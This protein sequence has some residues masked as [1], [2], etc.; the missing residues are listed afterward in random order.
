M[1]LP[2]PSGA[3]H[4]ASAQAPALPG[5]LPRERGETVRKRRS[6]STWEVA[7]ILLASFVL[8]LGVRIYGEAERVAEIRELA[9]VIPIGAEKSRVVELL[10]PPDVKYSAFAGLVNAL[11]GGKPSWAY[12][13]PFVDEFPY[14]FPF[15]PIFDF[16]WGPSTK[17]VVVVFDFSGK[18]AAVHVPPVR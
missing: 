1:N 14:Y 13:S 6:F 4:G 9:A 17:D 3:L 8:L 5:A 15:D 11:A 12:E 18:V 10:G 2:E 16:G 7:G